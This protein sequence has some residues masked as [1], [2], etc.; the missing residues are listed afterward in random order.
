MKFEI[1]GQEVKVEFN[2]RSIKTYQKDGTV[3]T[4]KLDPADT[5]DLAAV[6]TAAAVTAATIGTGSAISSL[7]GIGI[8]ALGTAISVPLF[9][10]LGLGIMAAG[11]P[12]AIYAAYNAGTSVENYLAE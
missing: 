4:L 3:S 6:S 9:P 10:V 11:I 1:P 2:G 7:G 12:A 5:G 8:A